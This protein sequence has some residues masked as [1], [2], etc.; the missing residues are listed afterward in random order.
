MEDAQFSAMTIYVENG[1]L[2][3]APFGLNIDIKVEYEGVDLFNTDKWQ[4]ISCIFSNER[5]VKGQYLAVNLDPE[6]HFVKNFEQIV[7]TPRSYTQIIAAGT[8]SYLPNFSRDN[9]WTV[10]VGNGPYQTKTIYGTFKDIRLWKTDRSD[11]KLYA[12][13]FQQVRSSQEEDLAASFK[14]MSGNEVVIN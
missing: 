4:H 10:I 13:R 1:K 8:K 14:L 5:Y 3:C 6:T 7:L 11:G 12:H 2:K 9:Q